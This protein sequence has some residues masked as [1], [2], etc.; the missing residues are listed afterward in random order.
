MNIVYQQKVQNLQVL[1]ECTT[2]AV[3]WITPN[4][5]EN[6][7]KE[8]EYCLEYCLFV[9]TNNV[10]LKS[11]VTILQTLNSINSHVSLELLFSS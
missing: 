10:K 8:K 5:L 4:M 9:L 6:T 3:A 1:R 11:S 7:L 2:N